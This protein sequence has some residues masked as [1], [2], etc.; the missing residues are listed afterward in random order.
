VL[1]VEEG[2]PGWGFA[3]EC[4]RALIGR[5]KHFSALTGPNHPVPSSREWEDDLLPGANAIQA[6]CIDLFNKG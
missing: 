1:A 6:A 2:T 3:S 5:V 4:A